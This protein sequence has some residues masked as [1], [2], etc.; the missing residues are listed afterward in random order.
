MTGPLYVGNQGITS[1]TDIF[2]FLP[3]NNTTQVVQNNTQTQMFQPIGFSSG[4][5]GSVRATSPAVI[6]AATI[7]QEFVG[8]GTCN[9]T[10]EITG[11]DPDGNTIGS[12]DIESVTAT[13]RF[14]WQGVLARR[15]LRGRYKLPCLPHGGLCRMRFACVRSMD[16]FGIEYELPVLPGCGSGRRWLNTAVDNK[17]R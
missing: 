17:R 10:Y 13:I 3:V 1:G 6:P 2:G 5:A 4:I 9:I 15:A 12:N 8:P 11:V 14:P 7:T 16:G